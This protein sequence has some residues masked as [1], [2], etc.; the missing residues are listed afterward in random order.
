AEEMTNIIRRRK[1]NLN[2]N[3]TP[4]LLSAWSL[5]QLCVRRSID[6]FVPSF[7]PISNFRFWRAI[8]IPHIKAR[9][10]ELAGNGAFVISGYA[11]DLEAYYKE[12]EEMVFY[13]SVSDLAQKIKYYLA[14][15]AER[16]GILRAG[17]ERTLR[18]HTYQKRF[19]KVF[20][21]IGLI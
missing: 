20:E 13:R 7:R 16:E 3:D 21:E 1:N 14:H 17:V 10:F 5:S 9:P 8:S 4:P 2:K 15:D 11:D 12:N 18:E 6:G 19:E